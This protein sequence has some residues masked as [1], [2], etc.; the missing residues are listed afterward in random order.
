[1]NIGS[2]MALN[3][4]R[5]PEKTAFIYEDKEYSYAAFNR[6]VNQLSHGLLSL[7]VEKGDKVALMLKNTD[8]F[9]VC[10]YAAAKIGAVLVPM[11]F[12]LVAREIS[13]ILDQSDSVMVFCDEEFDDLIKDAKQGADTV[14]H[15]VSVP[16]ATVPGHLSFQDAMSENDNEPGI[17]V[18]EK[19]DLH[20]LYTSGTTG[21]PKGALF[22][23]GQVIMVAV[24]MMGTM[25]INSMD[26][27]LHVAPLFHAA[28]LNMF[29]NPGLFMGA[30]HVILKDFDPHAVLEMIEK[31]KITFFFGVP[32]MYNMMVQITN[33]SVYDLSSVKGCGY[34]AAPM[35]A[36][37][38]RQAMGL[39]KTDQFFNLAGLTEAG[40]GGIYL[41]PEDHK[42]KIGAS[43]KLPLMFLEA[44]V[45]DEDG[46]DINTDAVGELIFRGET[47]MKEYYKKPLETK[48][49]VRDGWLYTGDLAVKDEDGYITLVDRS[50]DMIISGGENVYSVEVEQVLN[51]HP[52]VLEAAVI[53]TP[54]S[55]WGEMV[56][57]IIVL[58]QDKIIEENDLENFCRQHLAGYKIPRKINFTDQ[59]SRNASG[60]LLKYQLRE[61]YR[62]T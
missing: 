21:Q 59:L 33:E 5:H 50:K 18:N 3:A 55:K 40:P 14:R 20:I 45:V 25:G 43:G 37:L 58:K 44:R 27:F 39:F 49:T 47:V 7:G 4:R 34:G 48:E 15:V 38:V 32:T 61:Q 13:Y 31:Y 9:P 11:N 62:N 24:S 60:K 35:D 51:M 46:N 57:A 1:M 19:D 16:N 28:Q 2:Y 6:T 30:T 22:D 56:T 42:T 29:L 17:E 26:R 12:R 41:T 52:G 54:D 36:E 23:H 8:F 10:Y 53:G